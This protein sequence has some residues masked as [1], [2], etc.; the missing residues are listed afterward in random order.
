MNKKNLIIPLVLFVLLGIYK[1]MSNQAEEETMTESEVTSTPIKTNTSDQITL[2]FYNVEN[3][4]DTENDPLTNDDE[5]TPYGDLKWDD[6]R[7]QLKLSRIAEVI[8]DIDTENK[9]A[10]MGL[11]EV[12][13]ENVL[14]DLTQQNQLKN[15]PYKIIHQDNHDGRGIDVAAIYNSE[16]VTVDTYRY[17]P[18]LIE[19][20]DAPNGRDILEIKARFYDQE[21][22]FIYVTHWP[23]RRDGTKETEYKRMSAAKA[24]RS[25]I[26]ARLKVNPDERII[27]FGDFND[28]PSDKSL[29][30]LQQSDF[31]NLS[32]RFQKQEKGTV[33]HQGEWLM[34]DQILVS[35]YLLEDN[36]YQLSKKSAFIFDED[37]VSFT[38]RSG[39]VTPNR[40]YSG[41]KYHGG[42][43][44]HYAVYLKM[45][46][47]H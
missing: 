40:T 13:N 32:Q 17:Y 36:N 23:S 47:N 33:N 6:E 2:G 28:E 29:K 27:I 14:A 25:R 46:V 12:E 7:Y 4:F 10:F 18:V 5:F 39:D 38:H 34:F 35:K 15:T 43:S 41:Y 42:Y 20:Y 24:L 8:H 16:I 11:T 1:W 31:Y 30:T 9:P 21:P 22:I 37:F 3:L 26:D 19:G 45:K 44:D